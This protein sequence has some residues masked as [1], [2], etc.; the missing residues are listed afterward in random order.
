[1]ESNG[2][3][4]HQIQQSIYLEVQNQTKNGLLKDPCQGFPT[5]KG[6]SL[7]DLDFLRIDVHS[8]YQKRSIKT[9]TSIGALISDIYARSA[10][11]S[12]EPFD[13]ENTYTYSKWD[14]VKDSEFL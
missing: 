9:K 11:K 10:T 12:S 5:T 14:N 4:K 1:M 13:S 2:E 6:Q 3:G 8:I 7:V